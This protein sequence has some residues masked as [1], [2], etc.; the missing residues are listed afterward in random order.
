MR[1]IGFE[2]IRQ[3]FG[4]TYDKFVSLDENMQQALCSRNTAD[5]RKIISAKA[6]F[7]LNLS[8]DVKLIP[9]GA[10]KKEKG[11]RAALSAWAGDAASFLENQKL[12]DIKNILTQQGKNLIFQLLR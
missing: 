2:E 11:L 12:Y 4:E 6:K 9:E 3:L 5:Y 7:I 1:S 8:E 10:D